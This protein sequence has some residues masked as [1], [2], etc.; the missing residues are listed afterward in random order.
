MSRDGSGNFTFNEAR[1]NPGEVIDADWMNLVL[2]DVEGG[3]T[4]SLSRSGKGGMQSPLPF[5]DG[6]QANPGMTWTSELGSGFFRAANGD[7]QLSVLGQ[8]YMR[9]SGNKTY[10]RVG[11]NWEEVSYVGSGSSIPDGDTGAG[12]TRLNWNGSAW[13]AEKPDITDGATNTAIATWSSSN[14]QWVENANVTVT[15]GG[16]I[17][18]AGFTGPLTGNVTGSVT[19]NANTATNAA[20]LGGVAAS[21]Y[22][23]D[24]ASSAPQVRTVSGWVA[25]VKAD[26]AD[27]SGETQPKS[28]QVMTGAEFLGITPDAA[29]VYFLT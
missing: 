18:A 20:Q 16:N 7:M 10:I 13:V 8:L 25:G 6:N 2:D 1:P 26:N 28:V 15:A 22:V 11:G 4:E 12:L 5:D 14:A 24:T 21:D 29:T 17:S 19:G 9:W 23:Q 27:S 3:L